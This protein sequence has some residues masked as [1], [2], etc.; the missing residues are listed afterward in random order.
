MRQINAL[1]VHCSAT[2]PHRDIGAAE[3]RRWHLD[4]GWRDIG[5]HCVIRRNGLI[6]DGRSVSLPGAHVSGHNADTIGI[7]LVG[8]VNAAGKAENNYTPD[9]WASL[10]WLLQNL[11]QDYPGAMIKGHR[12]F[13][14]VKKDCPCFDVGLWAA[15]VG[16][17]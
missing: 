16:L 11:L 6:E 9:Q 2:P 17:V 7:C 13:P 10:R 3:I 5:Y 4:R 15:A 1:V 14:K 8:G 12:D